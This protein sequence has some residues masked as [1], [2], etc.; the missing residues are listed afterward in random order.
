M[1]EMTIR[2]PQPVEAVLIA[3]LGL[4]LA[5]CAPKPPVAPGVQDTF[6]NRLLGP[7]IPVQTELARQ[8][9]V[10][11]AN[12]EDDAKCRELGFTPQT[13]AYGNCRLQLEQIRATNASPS[14]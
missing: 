3:C 5:G 9:G 13:E 12:A 11:A 2:D 10:G 4:A 6:I 8:A 14:Q 1:G 7:P